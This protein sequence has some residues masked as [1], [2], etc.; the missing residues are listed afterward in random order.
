MSEIAYDT[1]GTKN[2]VMVFSSYLGGAGDDRGRGIAVDKNG[3]AY[4]TGST[5]SAKGTTLQPFS[6]NAW[7]DDLAGTR[8]AF[9]TRV[10]PPVDGGPATVVFSSYLGG[11]GDDS[12]WGIAVTTNVSTVIYVT[13]DT[14]SLDANNRAVFNPNDAKNKM[15]S[16][17]YTGTGPGTSNARDAFIMRLSYAGTTLTPEV[18]ISFGGA[19]NDTSRGIAVDGG[20]AYVTGFTTSNDKADG[21]PKKN[22]PVGYGGRQDAFVAAFDT[23]KAAGARDVYNVYQGGSDIDSGMGVAVGT[24]HSVFAVGYTDFN[25]FLSSDPN[26]PP[27]PFQKDFGGGTDAWAVRIAAFT[28]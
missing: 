6:K 20:V 18:F 10:S 26:T 12:G 15:L 25:D 17:K 7:Q 11:T 16:D 27:N 9:L 4:V 8:N 28:P 13:G 5:T 21:Y 2:A 24:D 22:S 3:D 1:G 14:T 19:G 23:T